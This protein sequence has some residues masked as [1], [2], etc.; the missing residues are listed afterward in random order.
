MSRQRLRP[1]LG[2]S[3][4]SECPRC[5]GQGKIRGVESLGLSILRI[6]EEEA[7][8]ESTERIIAHLPVSVATFLLNEKRRVILDIESRQEVQV[9]LLPNEH[10][11]TPDYRIERVR[12]QDLAKQ[13]DE[14]PSFE[15]VTPPQPAAQPYGRLSETARSEE[16]AVKHVAPALPMPVREPPPETQTVASAPRRPEPA[17][18]TLAAPAHERSQSESLLKR[19]WTGLFAPRNVEPVQT[20]E[21]SP[22][23]GGWAEDRGPRAEPSGHPGQR[24]PD[25][26]PRGAEGR[27][28]ERRDGRRDDGRDPRR[29][30]GAPPVPGRGEQDRQRTGARGPDRIGER[31]SDR[32]GA[33]R[34]GARDAQRPQ[35]R[36]E[37]QQPEAQRTE[38]QR[39][40]RDDQGR[41]RREGD[42]RNRRGRSRGRREE[43]GTAGAEEGVQP[44]TRRDLQQPGEQ[45]GQPPRQRIEGNRGPREDLPERAPPRQEPGMDRPGTPRADQADQPGASALVLPEDAGPSPEDRPRD[46]ILPL[47]VAPPLA[48][49]GFGPEIKGAPATDADTI[50]APAPALDQTGPGQVG[51]G[52]GPP[53]PGD[54]L[55]W[56]DARPFGQLE[57][58]GASPLETE[59]T[60]LPEPPSEPMAAP[61]WALA[62]P[63]ADV[64][65]V[66]AQPEVA[67]DA[68]GE[69]AVTVS[70]VAETDRDAAD[71]DLGSAAA[72]PRRP[73][74]ETR[75]SPGAGLGLKDATPTATPEPDGPEVEALGDDEDED[76]AEGEGE[77]PSGEAAPAEHRR[78]PRRRRGGGRNRRRPGRD[79]T[80]AGTAEDAPEPV[81]ELGQEGEGRRPDSADLAT[82][83]AAE[84][85]DDAT[86]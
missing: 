48:D 18:D 86:G 4:T 13:P 47:A 82:P 51:A 66:V 28:D 25:Q 41:D 11:E 10:I 62:R 35:G 57:G 55:E 85:K 74:T 54:R 50:A 49:A 81:S 20:P 58:Q 76:R 40:P 77:D 24:R 29:P 31:T 72:L 37:G 64:E 75:V 44:E 56:D 78:S 3:T 6:I 63:E 42:P 32:G 68:V 65:P 38:G 53:G 59:V 73:E 43:A 36:I 34:S 7:M 21:R 79:A 52:G 45:P 8:K 71:T 83:R 17:L 5:H 2:D 19:I 33:D 39:P 60:D 15:M 23:P 22:E 12:S 69:P 16:P 9:V 46:A 84:V 80:R 27:R 30:Q 61:R 26:R 14:R 1:S 70:A 67:G